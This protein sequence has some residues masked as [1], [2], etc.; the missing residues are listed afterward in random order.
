MSNTKVA[1]LCLSHHQGGMELDAL[2]HT[3]LFNKHGIDSILICKKNTFLQKKAEEQRVEHFSIAFRS[4]LS[5]HLIKELKRIIVEEKITTLVFLGASEIKS[6]YFA[7]KGTNCKVIVRHGTTKST[8][9]KDFLHKLFYSCVSNYVAISEHLHQNVLDILPANKNQVITIYPSVNQTAISDDTP[10]VPSFI[11]VGRAESG[12]GIFD[13]VEALS[14]ADIPNENKKLT[15]VGPYEVNVRQELS[16]LVQDKGI[17][18]NFIGFTDNVASYYR[19]NAF[20]LFPSYGEGFGNVVLEAMSHGLTCITYNNTIFPEFLTL[21]FSDFYQ[22]EDRD[23]IDLA[24][25]IEQATKDFK[26]PKDNPHKKALKSNFSE[27]I[28]IA[29]WKEIII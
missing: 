14:S 4:K 18:L 23:I 1:V 10:K 29:R 13:A 24:R 25:K 20:F 26:V 9:K 8:S 15:I 27:T 17:E 22:A 19:E 3:S 6:I 16:E 7:V 11:F 12:K 2:R 5:L 28:S 21:G